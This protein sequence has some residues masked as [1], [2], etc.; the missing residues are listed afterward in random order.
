M[1]LTREQK[2]RIRKY[3]N[4][5]YPLNLYVMRI[6]DEELAM[7]YFDFYNSV[8]DMGNEESRDRF[9]IND[10]SALT[11]LCRESSGPRGVL[12][13]LPDFKDWSY[14]EIVDTITHES[15]HAT[16]AFCDY[17]GMRPPTYDGGDEHFTYLLGWIAGCVANAYITFKQEDDETD[18][19]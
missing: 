5:I 16:T 11:I 8:E 2:K 14:S 3:N 18:T 10:H 13:M 19:K 7:N 15:G 12:I 6:S 17:L 4:D 9:K 1:K